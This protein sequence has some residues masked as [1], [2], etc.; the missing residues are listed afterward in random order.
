MDHRTEEWRDRLIPVVALVVTALIG[1]ALFLGC[2]ITRSDPYEEPIP[3]YE[4]PV[5]VKVIPA[6]TPTPGDGEAVEDDER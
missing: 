3:C 6:P 2:A 1:A 4:G 5:I